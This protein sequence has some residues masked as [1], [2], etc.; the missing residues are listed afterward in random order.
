MLNAAADLLTYLELNQYATILRNSI[1][2][3]VNVAKIHTP[4]LGGSN[5]TTDVVDYIIHDVKA[6]TQVL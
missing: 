3:V 2:R 4:D 1:D 5:S 6:Q